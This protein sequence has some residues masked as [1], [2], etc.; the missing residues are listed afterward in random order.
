MKLIALFLLSVQLVIARGPGEHKSIH[1]LQSEQHRN[2]RR[3]DVQQPARSIPLEPKPLGIASLSKKV[4]GWH[5]DWAPSTAYLGYDY[6]VLSHIGYFSYETDTATGGCTTLNGWTTTPIIDTAHKHGV[7]AVLVVTNFGG[8]SN[9]RIL[10]DSAKQT[11]M[12]N[13]LIQLLLARSGDGINF[14][15]EE[16]NGAQRSNLVLFMQHVATQVKARIPGAEISMAMPAVDWNNAFDLLHLSQTC[17]YLILMGYD[18][19][20]GGSSTA[21]PVAPLAGETYDV[22]ISVNTY[23]SAGVDPG[24]L[25]LGVPWYGYDWPVTGTGRKSRSHGIR[26][27]LYLPD[28]GN[29]KRKRMENLRFND[30]S[31]VVFLPVGISMASGL[32]R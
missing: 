5:P 18:Y 16:V 21:G 9:D 19:Y 3:V 14:D 26:N 7:K 11:T 23:L 6:S 13:T 15:F 4:F 25:L 17:D 8:D 2:E 12:I 32:V 27:C 10:E 29:R 31:S 28:S 22:T 24:K 1:R 20:W 30:G